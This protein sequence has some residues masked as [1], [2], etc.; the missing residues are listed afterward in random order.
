MTGTHA[1]PVVSQS[2]IRRSFLH[3]ILCLYTTWTGNCA[4]KAVTR[5]I[6]AHF[7]SASLAIYPLQQATFA[8]R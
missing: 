4:V 5:L 3:C 2:T 7:S 1:S 6:L 8:A